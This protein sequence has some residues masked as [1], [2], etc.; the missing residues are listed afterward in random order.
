VTDAGTRT[1][2]AKRCSSLREAEEKYPIVAR[3]SNL[4]TTE[5]GSI[6]PSNEVDAS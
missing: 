6:P 3:K 4:Q 2:R 5:L 1:N